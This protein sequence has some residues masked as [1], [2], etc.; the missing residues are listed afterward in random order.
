MARYELVVTVLFLNQLSQSNVKISLKMFAKNEP[1]PRYNAK[2]LK[3]SFD[4]ENRL[5][6]IHDVFN[7]SLKA[8]PVTG[9]F[10]SKYHNTDLCRVDTVLLQRIRAYQVGTPNQKYPAPV[11][12]NQRYGWIPVQ[13]VPL[14]K[15]DVRYYAPRIATIS[16]CMTVSHVKK[17]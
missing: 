12:E 16:K 9:K 4:R 1:R 3:E 8:A 6:R 5:F 10:Y 14:R 13:L 11:T 2:V 17:K 7:P 15:A